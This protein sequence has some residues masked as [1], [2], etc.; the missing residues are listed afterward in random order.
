MHRNGMFQFQTGAI[1]SFLSA[2]AGIGI[3]CFNS[4]LVRLKVCGISPSAAQQKFQF[5]TG[6]IKRCRGG[7]STGD[8]E[9]SF[10]SKLVR[11]K[12]LNLANYATGL[13]S[14]N[15]KLVRLKENIRLRDRR[16]FIRF[17]F[18]TGAI[19]RFMRF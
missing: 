17:Q 18:Q 9:I 19:K 5:Q 3:L 6:A 12:G 1:K 15:S 4:K 14:F 13:P 8:D 7:D 11:L 16:D 10:N 2:P